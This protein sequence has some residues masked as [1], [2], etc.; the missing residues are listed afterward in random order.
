MNHLESVR[1]LIDCL[2]VLLIT[3]EPG[4]KPPEHPH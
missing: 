2:D 1:N 3:S 4:V